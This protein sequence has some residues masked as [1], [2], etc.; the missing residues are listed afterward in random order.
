[1]ELRRKEK[2]SQ[3]HRKLF[4]AKAT[5][6]GPKQNK[7]RKDLAYCPITR[8]RFIRFSLK[9]RETKHERRRITTFFSQFLFKFSFSSLLKRKHNNNRETMATL[10]SGAE[11]SIADLNN[12]DSPQN[13]CG[14][15]NDP[16]SRDGDNV[17]GVGVNK[18][19]ARREAKRLA[20]LEHLEWKKRTYPPFESSTATVSNVDDV[21]LMAKSSHRRRCCC[22]SRIRWVRHY[23]QKLLHQKQ[24]L[25]KASSSTASQPSLRSSLL[26]NTS[27]LCKFLSAKK[28]VKLHG[29]RLLQNSN[30]NTSEEVIA[31]PPEHTHTTANNSNHDRD[32]NSNASFYPFP[33]P[34]IS[35]DAVDPE[36]DDL[37]DTAWNYLAFCA[38]RLDWNPNTDPNIRSDPARTVIVCRLKQ[39]TT[40]QA[41]VEVMRERFGVVLSARLVRNL[42][43]PAQPSRGYCFVEFKHVGEAE[44]AVRASGDVE[45]DGKKNIVI[46]FER[47]RLQKEAPSLRKPPPDYKVVRYRKNNKN[48]SSTTTTTEVT[49]ST[50]NSPTPATGK[51]TEASVNEEIGNNNKQQQRRRRW[52]WRQRSGKRRGPNVYWIDAPAVVEDDGSFIPY[53]LRD[54][55]SISPL[56]L[57]FFKP[58]S[59]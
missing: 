41:V 22:C 18:Y 23:Q 27:S 40:E 1:M 44:A 47:G 37:P 38:E 3:K 46:D 8:F 9:E 31:C 26:G 33:R 50:V 55:A 25:Q 30:R 49:A 2:I 57:V 13:Q 4:W 19:M 10:L 16:H 48:N 17:D 53:R 39:S 24:Q 15:C 56:A 45:I 34:H 35:L 12:I 11:A 28:K 54:R 6:M 5:K 43:H 14:T 51:N 36:S 21:S 58:K 42:H 32:D 52:T 29:I 20:Y 7:K 59:S